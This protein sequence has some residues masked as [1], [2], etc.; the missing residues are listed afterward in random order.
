MTKQ[1]AVPSCKA[2]AMFLGAFALLCAFVA[3]GQVNA[4]PGYL[5]DTRGT[6]V[7]N[8]TYLCWHTGNWSPAAAIA[9]CDPDLVAKPRPIAQAEPAAAPA[10][11]RPAPAPAPATPPAKAAAIPY[12][13]KISLSAEA[14]FDFDKSVLKPE[15]RKSLDELAAKA[16]AISLDV[17]IALGHTD[18][19]GTAA[20]NQAL[21]MRRANAVKA[22]LLSKGVAANR[23]TAEGKGEKQ[24]VA[25]NKT[26]DGRARNRRVE[27]E[28][29]GT[30]R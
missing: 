30:G 12:M 17:I 13:Q 9:E 15:G 10:A 28:V 2:G 20:Y 4:P 6:V 22:Y 16:A 25:D 19:I 24:P 1:Y 7:R 5:T 26:G 3:H 11:A 21:S 23:V 27:V 8:A 14:L 18:S 29:I